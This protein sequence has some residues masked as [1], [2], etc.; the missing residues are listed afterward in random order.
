MGKEYTSKDVEH[1]LT[2]YLTTH[3]HY[4]AKICS[5]LNLQGADIAGNLVKLVNNQTPFISRSKD[6][7]IEEGNKLRAEHADLLNQA[8]LREQSQ[9]RGVSNSAISQ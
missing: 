6:L 3:R 9:T 7:G 5:T 4:K 8:H 2:Q 1:I